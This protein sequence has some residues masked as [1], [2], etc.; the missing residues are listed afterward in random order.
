MSFSYGKSVKQHRAIRLITRERDPHRVFRNVREKISGEPS[1]MA[2]ERAPTSKRDCLA[3]SFHPSTLI[4]LLHFAQGFVI[5]LNESQQVIPVHC[6]IP[7]KPIQVQPTLFLNRIPGWPPA[8]DRVIIPISANRHIR[9]G[10]CS[11]RVDF[12]ARLW[13]LQRLRRARS[14]R[15]RE[16]S[17]DAVFRGGVCFRGA[18]VCGGEAH[19]SR[20]R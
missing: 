15:F 4:S 17:P 2:H 6:T 13:G 11:G 20:L 8:G 19:R 1:H 16:K 3:P 9:R 7:H 12:P 14:F 18:R 10:F 5:D